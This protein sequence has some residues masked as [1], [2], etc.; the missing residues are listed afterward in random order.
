MEI[1]P[2]V[3]KNIWL[4]DDD[5]DDQLV[6]ENALKEIDPSL[7]LKKF[8]TC[9]SLLQK[10]KD[11]QPDLLFLDINMPGING[12]ECLK[13]IKENSA[14]K[15]LPVIVHSGS[16]YKMDILTSYGFGATLYI[17]KP[18]S[19]NNIIKTLEAVLSLDWSDPETIMTNQ[20]Q[21]N[22]FVPFRA[23]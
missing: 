10:L 9:E 18:G 7:Q 8:A 21:D 3:F 12:K 13:I 6:F 20:Y 5:E 23:D 16:D 17:V 19:Y 11:D 2:S 14:Y 22:R 15:K 1:W 4:A